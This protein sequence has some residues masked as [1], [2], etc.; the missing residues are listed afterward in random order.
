MPYLRAMVSKSFLSLS[1][2]FWSVRHSA[3]L[4]L[5]FLLLPPIYGPPTKA[6][7]GTMTTG[8]GYLSNLVMQYHFFKLA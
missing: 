5:V 7:K 3:T 1:M 6:I 2:S 8:F 4:L